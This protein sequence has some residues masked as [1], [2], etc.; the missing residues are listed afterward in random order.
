MKPNS[1][2]WPLILLALAGG[3]QELG[4]NSGCPSRALKGQ[5]AVESNDDASARFDRILEGLWNKD[6]KAREAALK[7]VGGVSEGE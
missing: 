5:P 1:L 7:R 4:L 6:E 3:F 2:G